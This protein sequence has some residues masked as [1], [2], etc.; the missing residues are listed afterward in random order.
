MV[1]ISTPCTVR[2]IGYR[3]SRIPYFRS[4]LG[5]IASK[6]WRSNLHSYSL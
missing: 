2:D 4:L 3:A 5:K 6:S 1:I